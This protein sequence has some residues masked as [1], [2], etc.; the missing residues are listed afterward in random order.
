M[1]KAHVILLMLVVLHQCD[2]TVV[3]EESQRE[4]ARQLR[5]EQPQ[6]WKKKNPAD[7]MLLW[8]SEQYYSHRSNHW[9]EKRQ[10][11]GVSENSAEGG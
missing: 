8:N 9:A 5:E 6:F 3:D 1:T 7:E 10:I 4:D 2:D 11:V